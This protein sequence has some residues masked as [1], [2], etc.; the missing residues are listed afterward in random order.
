MRYYE[1]ISDAKVDMLLPQVPKRVKRKIAADF[2]IDLGVLKIGW[3]TERLDNDTRVSRLQ[4]VEQ[5]LRDNE[6][7][8]SI[9]DPKTPWIAGQLPMRWGFFPQEELVF[10]MGRQDSTYIALGGSAHHMLSRPGALLDSGTEAF[11]GSIAPSLLAFI[12]REIESIHSALEREG[13]SIASVSRTID[14]LHR[15]PAMEEETLHHIAQLIEVQRSHAHRFEFLAKR[16]LSGTSWVATDSAA[17]AQ[18][19]T[20]VLGTPLFVA[21]DE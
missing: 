7:I 19:V 20:V 12:R 9:A 15:A 6:P 8:A 17:P 14:S 18:E 2:N 13:T 3:K 5:Y 10:F 11:P 1:Y 16:L 21:L 4:V